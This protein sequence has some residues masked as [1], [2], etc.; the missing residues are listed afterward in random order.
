M[1]LGSTIVNALMASDC[2]ATGDERMAQAVAHRFGGF[3]IYEM[4][5]GYLCESVRQ[6]SMCAMQP[7]Y[8]D[9]RRMR[10]AVIASCS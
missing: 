3:V 6:N 2:T 7:L 5:A 8:T 1:S 4:K 10:E 9:G